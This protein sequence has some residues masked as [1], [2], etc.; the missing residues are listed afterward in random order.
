MHGGKWLSS[1]L[2][3]SLTVGCTNI[4]SRHSSATPKYLRGTPAEV[5]KHMLTH[6]PTGTPR[7]EAYRI[8]KSLGL[9]LTPQ[10]ELATVNPDAIECRHVGP[11]GLFS[12][13]TWLIRIDCPNGKV[14]D[15]LC[16]P[17]TVS[18]W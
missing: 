10:S 7:N 18:F 15:I 3:V 12:Q 13:T 5:R 9:E 2:V 4:V 16:E 8:I 1:L 11:Q 14:V 6:I 17:I